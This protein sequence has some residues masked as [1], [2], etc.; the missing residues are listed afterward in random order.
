[1]KKLLIIFSLI[2]IGCNQPSET[3]YIIEEEHGHFDSI[4][5]TQDSI[6]ELADKIILHVQNQKLDK[7]SMSTEIEH[8]KHEIEE[9]NIHDK[10]TD[11]QIQFL[12]NEEEE[13]HHQIFAQQIYIEELKAPK[14]TIIYNTQYKDTIIQKPIYVNDTIHIQIEIIDTIK[15]KK[16][17]RRNK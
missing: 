4:T 17:K 2:I 11:E 1:M 6:L 3:S 14:D 5:I 15:V 13:L 9:R 16:K 8:H 7:A 12:K 10:L